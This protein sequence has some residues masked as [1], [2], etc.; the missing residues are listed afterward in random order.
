VAAATPL[1]GRVA[2][3]PP[4]EVAPATSGVARGPP[5]PKG[6]P[7]GLPRTWGGCTATQLPGWPRATLGVARK[8]PT[9]S[10]VARRPSG[11]LRGWL[12][13]PPFPSVSFSFLFLFKMMIFG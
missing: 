7:H 2:C 6:W 9:A 11:H 13:P 12:L 5:R 4:P 10:G 3:Q 8:P 1:G